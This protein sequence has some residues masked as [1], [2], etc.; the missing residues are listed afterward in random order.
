MWNIFVDACTE[1]ISQFFKIDALRNILGSDGPV[2]DKNRA[3]PKNLHDPENSK[4]LEDGDLQPEAEFE[5]FSDFFLVDVQ[6][7]QKTKHSEDKK[8]SR[9]NKS[10]SKF[11]KFIQAN[12]LTQTTSILMSI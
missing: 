4:I 8:K 7:M 2:S 9:K 11:A 5:L 3:V 1:Y 6:K 10:G 12:Y